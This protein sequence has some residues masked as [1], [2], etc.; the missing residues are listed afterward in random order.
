MTDET[1]VI[2]FAP[3]AP[4]GGGYHTPAENFLA[5]YFFERVD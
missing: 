2:F 3:F 5:V 4:G 1:A